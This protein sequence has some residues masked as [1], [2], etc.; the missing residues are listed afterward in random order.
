MNLCM[1]VMMLDYRH[2]V[3]VKLYYSLSVLLKQ[4][5]IYCFTFHISCLSTLIMEQKAYTKGFRKVQN[6]M[7]SRC[8]FKGECLNTYRRT[9]NTIFHILYHRQRYLYSIAIDKISTSLQAYVFFQRHIGYF[10]MLQV[11]IS[12]SVYNCAK[13]TPRKELGSMRLV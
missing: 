9:P 1:H 13:L 2:N 11:L 5:P 10:G 4:S 3:W 12:Y 7:G 6:N 8:L